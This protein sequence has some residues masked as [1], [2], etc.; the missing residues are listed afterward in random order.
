MHDF[1]SNKGLLRW[2]MT[3][4]CSKSPQN[5]LKQ[6]CPTIYEPFLAT[7]H[8]CH[9]INVKLQEVEWQCFLNQNVLPR[10]VHYF[11]KL[12]QSLLTGKKCLSNLVYLTYP[13]GKEPIENISKW[14]VHSN[15]VIGQALLSVTA[16]GDTW[17]MPLLSEG[18]WFRSEQ[19]EGWEFSRWIYE[20]STLKSGWSS[21]FARFH[22]DL[23][24]R[25]FTRS[26]HEWFWQR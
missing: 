5:S 25:T 9:A 18:R 22:T 3:A 20:V 11:T 14:E 23:N 15:K 16:K 1:T 8:R 10:L 13:Y 6:M 19:Q 12:I 21:C 17:H 7:S 24:I 4:K 2:I 26:G